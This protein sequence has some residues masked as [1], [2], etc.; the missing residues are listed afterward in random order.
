MRIAIPILFACALLLAAC[1]KESPTGPDNGGTLPPNEIKVIGPDGGSIATTGFLL[2]V[3]Q[4][5][6]AVQE[7]V[8]IWVETG[9]TDFG[10]S[11]LSSAFRI[12]GLPSQY[13]HPLHVKLTCQRPPSTGTFVA[14]GQQGTSLPAGTADMIYKPIPATDSSGYLLADIPQAAGSALKA[15]QRPFGT[16]GTLESFLWLTAM[17]QQDTM[18]SPK[19]HFRIFYPKYLEG[20]VADLAGYLED[21]YTKYD[22]MG[23]N[24]GTYEI[25]EWPVPVSVMKFNQTNSGNLGCFLLLTRDS[26]SHPLWGLRFNEDRIISSTSSMTGSVAADVFSYV[27]FTHRDHFFWVSHTEQECTNEAKRVW[28]YYAIASWSEEKFVPASEQPLYVPLGFQGLESRPLLGISPA[29]N[30]YAD[31]L[32]TAMS[33]LIKY[34]AGTYSESLLPTLYSNVPGSTHAADALIATIPD[35]PDVWW[36]GFLKQYISGGIYNVSSDVLLKQF[37]NTTDPDQFTIA[38]PSDTAKHFSASYPDFSAKLYTVNLRYPDIKDK[39]WLQFTLGPGDLNFKYVGVM[40]F[41]LKDKKL[42]YWGFGHELKLENIKAL[43]AAGYDVVAAVINSAS[44]PPYDGSRTIELTVRIN[45]GTGDVP[46]QASLIEKIGGTLTNSLFNTLYA[47]VSYFSP[48]SGTRYGILSDHKYTA[49]WNGHWSGTTDRTAS[50]DLVLSFDNSSPPHLMSFS[51]RDTVRG[52]GETYMWHLTS[53]NNCNIPGTL[54]SDR[55][56]FQVIGMA[57]RDQVGTLEYSYARDNGYWEKFVAFDP[58]AGDLI[59]IVV[60]KW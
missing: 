24:D 55:Y 47:Y 35:G 21:A 15:L 53:S 19:R 51:L 26:Q 34:L 45:G 41:G 48:Y 43:T 2:T 11:M 25:T 56:V 52:Q 58:S 22:Q 12:G 46:L 18:K 57:T 49:S 7:T 8:K 30:E 32:G 16:R 17:D 33:P 31:K 10:A 29:K 4:G 60:E 6:F 28:P 39:T 37:A 44:A 27:F 59:Y 38:L 40:L 3:P 23:F 5:T 9:N 13:A 36:P 1:N 42:E 50:G 20:K 54:E 14:L